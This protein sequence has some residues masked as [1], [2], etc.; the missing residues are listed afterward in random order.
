MR[1]ISYSILAILVMAAAALTASA[2]VDET[3]V[4][5]GFTKVGS[6]GEFN[7]H[8]KID[9]T[10]GVKLVGRAK[11][12]NQIETI[13]KDGELW[14]QWKD[15]ENEHDIMKWGA[16]DIYVTVKSLSGIGSAGT[17]NMVVEGTVT[18]D[19]FEIHS[20]GPGNILCAVNTPSLY[21]TKTGSGWLDLSGNADNAKIELIGSGQLNGKELKTNTALVTLVGTANAYLVVNKTIGGQISGSGNV[22][23]TGN[24]TEGGIISSGSGRFLKE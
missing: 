3:R 17:G 21:A 5:S 4:V 7:V 22:N 9:A 11:T 12:I 24:A 15:S 10:E 2:Q 6:G 20:A 18:A 8:I 14:I 13:V 23:Y 19:K 16:V 1:K